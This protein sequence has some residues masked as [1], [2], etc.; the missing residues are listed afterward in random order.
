[1]WSDV[2]FTALPPGWVN[3]Y[4]MDDGTYETE[5]CPGVLLQ[6]ATQYKE[7]WDEEVGGSNVLR[8]RRCEMDRETRTVPAEICVGN[9]SPACDVSNY[10]TTATA[11]EW[12][13]QEAG[14]A[15]E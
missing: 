15:G 1:M 10:V 9:L 7:C 13:G 6:E 11:E 2:A 12:E 14:E 4:R 3:V 5:P 8:T